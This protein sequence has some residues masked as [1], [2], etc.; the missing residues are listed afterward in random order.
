M[1]EPNPYLAAYQGRLTNLL[2]WP[3]LDA[4]WENLQGR[5]QEG[6]YVYAVGEEPPTD[7]V[8]EQQFNAFLHEIGAL[9]RQEHEED[10]CGIVYVD[11]VDAP[12]FIKIY[13]PN[14]LGV[15]CGYSDNPPLP[16][17]TISQVPPCNLQAAFPPP[18]NRRRWWQRLFGT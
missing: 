17:W 5:S 3:Q 4:V 8:S 15:V 18:G 10:Y 1:S 7:T 13:D 11:N 16:G 14:N 9:L 2:R 12:R 6:W